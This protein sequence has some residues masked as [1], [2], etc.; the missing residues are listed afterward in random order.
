[1]KSQLRFLLVSCLC[2][3]VVNLC[4]RAQVL[5]VDVGNLVL[6]GLPKQLFVENLS[7]S[8]Q[9]VGTLQLNLQVTTT[10]GGGERPKISSVDLTTDTIFQSESGAPLGGRV[11]DHTWEIGFVADASLPD[12]A[13]PAFG[14]PLLA[15]ITFD[16][17]GIGPGPWGL[18]LTTLAGR[19]QFLDLASDDISTTLV[20][21][22]LSAVP[23]PSAY[24]AI[25]GL[26]SLGVAWGLRRKCGQ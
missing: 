18:S 15:T 1:M 21:G 19:S 26:A 5:K 25:F 14:K 10:A 23:E 3:V 6:D 22:S 11:D 16:A 2:L 20:D 17:S 24:A 7:G 9:G 13:V 8:S 12:P 4:G